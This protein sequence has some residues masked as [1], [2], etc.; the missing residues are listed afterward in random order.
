MVLYLCVCVKSHVSKMCCL[1]TS[2]GF[3]ISSE[4]T[5]VATMFEEKKISLNFLCCNNL[6]CNLEYYSF[7]LPLRLW[8][9]VSSDLEYVVF[10]VL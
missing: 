5:S 10:Q 9:Y 3:S 1:F 4:Q 8:Y 7:V 2:I 6:I